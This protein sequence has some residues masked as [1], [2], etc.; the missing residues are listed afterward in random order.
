MAGILF[1]AAGSESRDITIERWVA[2]AGSML[3]WKMGVMMPVIESVT[4][5]YKREK[6]IRDLCSLM[7]ATLRLKNNRAI[8]PEKLNDCTDEWQEQYEYIMEHLPVE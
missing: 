1:I 6:Q 4:K 2:L 8:F 7:L 5:L 3:I